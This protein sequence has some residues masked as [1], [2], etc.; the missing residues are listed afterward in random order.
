MLQWQ[1][2]RGSHKRSVILRWGVGETPGRRLVFLYQCPPTAT[3]QSSLRPFYLWPM[4]WGRWRTEERDGSWRKS[5]GAKCHFNR[6]QPRWNVKRGRSPTTD[7]ARPL[8]QG[9]GS[10]LI[11]APVPTASLH[12][13]LWN[14][15]LSFYTS[16]KLESDG[17]QWG[18]AGQRGTLPLRPSASA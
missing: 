17:K 10:S 11:T 18:T 2:R 5:W 1:N 13:N 16:C 3:Q 7:P 12:R 9:R 4:K 6:R 8:I 14:F 15:F